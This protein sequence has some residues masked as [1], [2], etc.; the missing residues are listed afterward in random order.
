MMILTLLSL[1]LQGPQPVSTPPIPEYYPAMA[2]CETAPAEMCI[3]ITMVVGEGA[4]AFTEKDFGR[5]PATIAEYA[6]CHGRMG[7][8]SIRYFDDGTAPS[9]VVGK[10]V[11]ALED[12]EVNGTLEPGG[13]IN[14]H[15]R[16]LIL[17]F[18]ATQSN[19]GGAEI[20]WECKL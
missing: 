5:D 13:L 7:R 4:R 14:L 9:S 12:E 15:N 19:W 10:L 17:G 1:L 8:G 2:P 11:P 20:V 3:N 18:K 6:V 16:N